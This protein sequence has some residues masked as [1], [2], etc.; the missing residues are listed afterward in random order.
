VLAVANGNFVDTSDTLYEVDLATGAQTP[1]YVSAGSFTIGVS[2][3]D[4]DSEMLYVPDAAA[5][6]VIELAW[7][8]NGF[9][10]VGSTEIAPGLALPPTQVYL[11]N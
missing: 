1:V 8:G 4:P 2:A 9:S 11:L 6:A 3:W 7:D 5:N 10:E